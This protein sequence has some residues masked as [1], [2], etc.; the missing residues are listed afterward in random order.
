M[1]PQLIA[2]WLGQDHFLANKYLMTG[3][4][5]GGILFPLSV[6]RKIS[7]LGYTSLAA[8]LSAIFVVV[9][10]VIRFSQHAAHNGIDMSKV[11]FV[12]KGFE[13]LFMSFP[14][15]FMAYGS[16]VTVVCIEKFF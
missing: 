8:I 2:T 3:I 15:Y 6:L 16:H 4:I 9:V 7:F 14:L 5:M 10:V 13:S 11:N 1:V 12:A